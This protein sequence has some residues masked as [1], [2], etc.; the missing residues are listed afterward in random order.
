MNA[1]RPGEDA[2]QICVEI[3]VPS[4]VNDDPHEWACPVSLKPLYQNLHDAHGGDAVQSL[5]LAISL[6]LDLLSGFR[7]KGGKLY[8]TSGDDFPLEAYSFGPA[9]KK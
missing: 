9:T 3:G 6:V 2:F 1:K 4:Q 7:E 8:N 5:C